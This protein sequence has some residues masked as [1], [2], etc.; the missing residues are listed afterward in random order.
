MAV[1]S[2]KKHQAIIV[3]YHKINKKY[4]K[5]EKESKKMLDFFIF[6]VYK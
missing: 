3:L 6:I 1:E 5:R 4:K 2:H